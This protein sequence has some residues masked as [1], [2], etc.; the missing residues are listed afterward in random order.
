M[1]TGE[2]LLPFPGKRMVWA[3]GR[4]SL[5]LFSETAG[6]VGTRDPGGHGRQPGGLRRGRAGFVDRATVPDGRTAKPADGARVEAAS[7]KPIAANRER[8]QALG[9]WPVRPVR[10]VQKTD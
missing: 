7:G 2:D 4:G 3:H 6:G 9:Q 1:I 10:Q 8:L 5:G